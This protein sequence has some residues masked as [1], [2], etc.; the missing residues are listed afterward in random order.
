MEYIKV[1]DKD[2]LF[3]DSQSEGIVS[4]DYKSYNQYIENYKRK[5]NENKKVLEIESDLNN[6]KSDINEIKT[7]LRS[8]VNGS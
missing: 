6:L 7:L 2:H 3:R 5:Y 8:L 1:K 4:D